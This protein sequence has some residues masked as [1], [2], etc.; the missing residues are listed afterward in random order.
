MTNPKVKIYPDSGTVMVWTQGEWQQADVEYT[1]EGM[2]EP[3]YLEDLDPEARWDDRT[4][5]T[6]ARDQ[7][8]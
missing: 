7:A 8:L 6:Y 1:Y 5:W 3:L 4:E 2:S